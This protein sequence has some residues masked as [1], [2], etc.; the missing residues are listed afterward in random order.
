METT[1]ANDNGRY[2]DRPESNPLGFDGSEVWEVPTDKLPAWAAR[3]YQRAHR[4]GVLD[5][6]SRLAA[7]HAK[8]LA[9]VAAAQGHHERAD[10]LRR[11]VCQHIAEIVQAGSKRVG[12]T[13][14]DKRSAPIL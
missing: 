2:M 6:S 1:T 9:E 12:G 4:H 13:S 10:Q 14:L 11:E 3:L 7:V 5:A 8:R